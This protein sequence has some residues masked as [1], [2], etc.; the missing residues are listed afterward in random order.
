[1]AETQ[2]HSFGC[3]FCTP[4]S[5][6]TNGPLSFTLV[7]VFAAPDPEKGLPPATTSPVYVFSAPAL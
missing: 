1:M 3:G 5:E 6:R 7:T 4:C 2:P